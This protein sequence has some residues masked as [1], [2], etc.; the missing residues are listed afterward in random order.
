VSSVTVFTVLLGNV[1]KQWKLEECRFW[2]VAPCS[3]CVNRRFGGTYRLHLQGRKIHEQGTSVSRWLQT[4]VPLLQGSRPHRLAAISHH[5]PALL[6]AASELFRQ[7]QSRVR[8][9]LRLTVY[10]HTANQFVL[11]PSS[12]RFT[13]RDFFAACGHSPYVASSLTRRWVYLLWIGFTFLK[14]THHTYSILLKW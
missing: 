11:A 1:F 9:T 8:V 10:C 5:P 4:D 7:S 12:L 3:S 14:Y 13:T 2:D 6:T